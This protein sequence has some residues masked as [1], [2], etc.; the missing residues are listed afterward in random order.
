MTVCLIP[1]YLQSRQGWESALLT[2]SPRHIGLSDPPGRLRHVRVGENQRY[3][4][5]RQGEVL[6]SIYLISSSRQGWGI[7][8]THSS[9]SIRY[10]DRLQSRQGWGVLTSLTLYSQRGINIDLSDAGY[11]PLGH[12]QSRQ[13]WGESALL[14]LLPG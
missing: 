9:S 13:G 1:V 12:L 3:S 10:K 7:N 8:V 5:L 6:I 4:L 2:L 14:V 11:N